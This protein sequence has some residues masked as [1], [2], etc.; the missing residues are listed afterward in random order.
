M[1]P[2]AQKSGLTAC[3]ASQPGPDGASLFG[4]SSK[5]IDGRTKQ[6]GTRPYCREPFQVNVEDLGTAVELRESLIDGNPKCPIAAWQG[7][8]IGFDR[9]VFRE[10][11]VGCGIGVRGT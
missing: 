2:P 1:R 3:V 4:K 6:I 7:D 11:L 10:Q 5:D 8:G 9:Q